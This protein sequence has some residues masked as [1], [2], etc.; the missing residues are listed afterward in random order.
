MAPPPS[1][2]YCK[3]AKAGFTETRKMEREVR[4]VDPEMEAK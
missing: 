1:P 4:M 3:L 2:L